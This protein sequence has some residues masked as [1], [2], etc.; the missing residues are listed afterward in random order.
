MKSSIGSFAGP[1]RVVPRGKLQFVVGLLA[2]HSLRLC[3]W[4]SMVLAFTSAQADLSYRPS[5]AHLYAI[6]STDGRV[7][8]WYGTKHKK[9]GLALLPPFVK[10]ALKSRRYLAKEIITT[11]EDGSDRVEPL[12]EGSKPNSEPPQRRSRAELSPRAKSELLKRGVP[13]YVFDSPMLCT[14]YLSWDDQ[15]GPTMD[16]AFELLARR[17]RKPVIGLDEANDIKES[18]AKLRDDLKDCDIEEMTRYVP[19]STLSLESKR[20]DLQ[21]L[22]GD[23]SKIEPCDE[24]CAKRTATWLNKIEA[25]HQAAGVFVVSGVAHLVG[26]AGGIDLLRARGYRVTQVESLTQ[27][28]ELLGRDQA[29]R[30]LKKTR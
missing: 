2:V 1:S 12:D 19:A 20:S 9:I 24:L 10:V 17:W 3:L 14:F 18:L 13:E 30:N 5:A 11:N 28:G 8:F 23:L 21:Y 27:M 7:S 25:L 15:A 22:Q 29:S 6:E 26:S 16:T 4:G